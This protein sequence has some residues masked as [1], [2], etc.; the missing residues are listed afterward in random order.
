MD[1][2]MRIAEACWIVFLVVWG[3]FAFST[4]RTRERDTTS[5]RLRYHLPALLSCLLMFTPVFW[6]GTLGQRWLPAGVPEEALGVSLTV[7]GIA[8][9]IWARVYIGSNWSGVVT[10]KENHQLIRTGPY[11]SVRHPIYSGMILAMIGTAVLNRR[12]AGLLAV[13]VLAAAFY[14]K[15][16]VEEQFMQRTFG[17]E[18]D[19]YRRR[20][21]SFLPRL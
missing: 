14:F 19:L 1:V 21:G 8:V 17:P 20:T 5:S 6:R 11:A 9:A 7:A 13:P 18:Y 2:G 15:S 3:L 12:W 16:R 10:V 4:K